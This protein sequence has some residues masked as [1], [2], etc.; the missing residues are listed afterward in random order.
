M[1]CDCNNYTTP[2]VLGFQSD[3]PEEEV[4]WLMNKSWK[5]GI[6]MF[7]KKKYLSSEKWCTLAMRFIDHLGSLKENH[8]AQV[9]R[10]KPGAAGMTLG[11]RGQQGYP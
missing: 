5:I 10:E 1:S 9:K 3:Y 4:F 8:E 2:T 7:K 6:R 11:Q